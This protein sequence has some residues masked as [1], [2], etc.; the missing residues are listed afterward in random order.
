ML[1]GRR[2][3]CRPRQPGRRRLWGRRRATP[4]PRGLPCR[5][6]GKLPLLPRSRRRKLRLLR[7]VLCGRAFWPRQHLPR[8]CRLPLNRGGRRRALRRKR[9]SG[10]RLLGSRARLGLPRQAAW[11][12][13]RR[14]RRRGS[15][16]PTLLLRRRRLLPF[17]RDLDYA[18]ARTLAAGGRAFD[19]RRF[20]PGGV[21]RLAGV[22]QRRKSA[23]GV[24]FGVVLA[25]IVVL[26]GIPAGRRP[27]SRL[28]PGRLCFRIGGGFF[29]PP[30][31]R[32]GRTPAFGLGKLPVFVLGAGFHVP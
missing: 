31:L 20:L 15:L 7:S 4:S 25:G 17:V 28:G 19:R 12:R 22:F 32:S 9:G 2:S 8:G 30:C 23:A 14:G 1:M 18:H 5:C 13:E 6:C 10:R 3:G 24:R 26:L 11:R 21:F 29:F 16:S 27:Q